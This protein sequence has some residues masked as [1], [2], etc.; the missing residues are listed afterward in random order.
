MNLAPPDMFHHTEE[1][2]ERL[3]TCLPLLLLREFILK[4][5]S[6]RGREGDGFCSIRLLTDNQKQFTC[7]R[8]YIKHFDLIHLQPFEQHEI[9]VCQPQEYLKKPAECDIFKI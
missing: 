4:N 1:R 3:T 6:G 8:D 2:A 9:N 5:A 7:S